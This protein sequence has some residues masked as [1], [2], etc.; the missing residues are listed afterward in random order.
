MTGTRGERLLGGTEK[1]RSIVLG[2][3]EK[4]AISKLKRMDADR[5][6]QAALVADL[7]AKREAAEAFARGVSRRAGDEQPPAKQARAV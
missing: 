4:L 3:E 1:A 6:K 7:K 2:N 5:A